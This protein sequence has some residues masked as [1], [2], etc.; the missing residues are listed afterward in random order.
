MEKI[1]KAYYYLF[2]KLYKMSEAAPSRWLSD[3]KAS[4]AIGV[5][6]IWS[7][8]SAINYYAIFTNT[9]LHLRFTNP[10]ILIPFISIVILHYFAFVRDGSIWRRY[11]ESFENFSKQK[12]LTGSIIV[13]TIIIFIIIS[14]FISIQYLHEI[15]YNK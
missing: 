15:F 5:L 9:K 10:I 2:Y 3:W 8:L 13:W 6:E 11:N 7:V 14:Y 12:N 1:K 4:F